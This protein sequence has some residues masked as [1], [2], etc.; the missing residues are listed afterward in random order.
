VF[1]ARKEALLG[2]ANADSAAFRK[3]ASEWARSADWR[4]RMAAAQ[5]SGGLGGR[6][7]ALD[8]A[9]SRVIAAA[10]SAW[11]GA[12]SEPDAI[13]AGEARRLL[14]HDDAA[15]RSI[16]AGILGRVSD[17]R[18]IGALARAYTRAGRD[19][20]P[21]AM[22]GALEALASIAQIADSTRSRVS[23]EFL[24]GTPAPTSYLVRRWAE[25]RWPEAARRWGP[26]YPLDPGRT[27][28]DYREIARR[29]IVAPDSLRRPHVIIETEQR[30]SIEVELLGP[31]APLTVANFISLVDR[32]FFDGNQWHRVIPNFVAQDG[33]PRG[34]GWGGPGSLI[35]DEINRVRYRD[36]VLGMAL[37]GPD[38]GSSQW[39][40]NLSPQPHLDGTYAVFGRVVGSLATLMR[41]TQGDV[42]RTIRR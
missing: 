29:F 26:A 11:D 20:F 1:A 3:V 38:T 2:L 35:R 6:P 14:T 19:S 30:G 39:F 8:D 41:I 13:L 12:L 42:I 32:R 16:A 21:D 24:T 23:R 9:D 33:D 34:D 25:E 31:E 27:L 4:E 17:P 36:P 18:D 10:F 22:L 15:V 5:G 28:Q 7:A 40:V 37:S